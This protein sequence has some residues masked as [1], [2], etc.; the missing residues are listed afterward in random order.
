MED[1]VA[2]PGTPAVSHTSKQAKGVC[3]LLIKSYPVLRQKKCCYL[4]HKT[5][6]QMFNSLST[7]AVGA[8]HQVFAEDC[9]LSLSTSI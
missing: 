3:N 8:S 9:H 5:V 6:L 1:S 7:D 2:I 4:I